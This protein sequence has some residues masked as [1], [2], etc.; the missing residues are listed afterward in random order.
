[1]G[2]FNKLPNIQLDNSDFE[3]LKSRILSEFG[4]PTVSIEITDENLVMAIKKSVDILNILAPRIVYPRFQIFP[5]KSDYEM[6]DYPKVNSVIDIYLDINYLVGMG[7][8]W[9]V[10]MRQPLSLSAKSDIS[11]MT[12]YVSNFLQYDTVN[13][14]FGLNFSKELIE[15]NIIRITPTP[16][17]Q[18]LVSVKLSVPHSE[19]LSS[20]NS[21]E[22]NWFIQFV[23]CKIGK[24]LSRI[25]GKFTGIQLPIGTLDN[26]ASSLLTESDEKEKSLID[27]LKA[28]YKFPESTLLIG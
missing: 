21:Y 8:P 6:I 3:E 24:M 19:D 20:L 25:R 12:D 17:Y 7:I 16:M 14:A 4:Y 18:G 10:L 27:E 23:Q 11:V 28:R 26:D 22:I 13:K 9:E 15:P 1:M 5:C 2:I